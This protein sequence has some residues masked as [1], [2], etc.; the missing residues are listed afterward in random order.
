LSAE[1][2]DHLGW[3]AKIVQTVAVL[4]PATT[5]FASDW[6]IEDESDPF[7][8]AREIDLGCWGAVRGRLRTSV[9]AVR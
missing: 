9:L 2:T 5:E 6:P 7:A 1:E 8:K 3:P 4:S